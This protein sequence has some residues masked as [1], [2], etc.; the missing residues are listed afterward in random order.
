M[1][2]T[3]L[4]FNSANTANHFHNNF[5]NK[6]KFILKN[7]PLLSDFD[8]NNVL[9]KYNNNNNMEEIKTEF[10]ND[11]D[12]NDE[13]MNHHNNNNLAFNLDFELLDS[14]TAVGFDP[15]PF[16]NLQQHKGPNHLLI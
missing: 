12:V 7:N 16:I 15:S 4:Y 5:E 1:E 9:N 13:I 2:V 14:W 6:S 3:N 11:Y 10:N 8:Q